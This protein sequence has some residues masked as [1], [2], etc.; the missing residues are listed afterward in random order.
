MITDQF[1]RQVFFTFY[2]YVNTA[3]VGIKQQSM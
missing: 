1:S 3:K 2:K